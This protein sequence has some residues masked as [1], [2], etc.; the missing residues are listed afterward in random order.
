MVKANK[1]LLKYSNVFSSNEADIGKTGLVQ[2]KIE[3]PIF[4]RPRRLPVALEKEVET[5]IEGMVKDGVI[6]PSSSPWCSPVVLV[7]KKDGSMRFCVDY[8]RL[9]DATKK[10]SYPLPRIDDTLDMLT[11]V[12][13][14]STLELK[15]G[16]WQ[17]EIHPK[18][19]EKIAFST[20]K[21]L[22]Q[23]KVMPF[24]LCNAPATFERLMELVLTG[25]IGDACLVYLDDIIIIGRTFE[26]HHQNLVRVLM[27]IQ[28]A[29]LKLSPKKCS[30]F[31]RQVSF[32]GY[33]VSEEGI[34]TDPEKIA[35][36]NEWPVP[37]D[38]TQELKNR[39]C[40]T[41]I[42]GYPD[43]GKEFIVDTDASDIGLG[44]VLSQRNGD[45]EIVIAYV[46]KSLSKSERN[47]CVTRREL[48]AVVKSLQHFSKYLLGRKFHLRTDHAALK[49]LLQFKN[50][51]G[52]VARWIEL[53]QEYDFVIE[54][55]SGR[56][57]GN[58]DALSRRPCPDCTASIVLGKRVR[59]W[60]L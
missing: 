42:L 7:K 3:L 11:G 58:A 52:Q 24:V 13:W 57:H 51:E 15:S 35:A 39:L 48:L 12:K 9:N 59:K 28:S 14:F 17:V 37:K 60:Y 31:K 26:E 6:E 49:W 36:I 29:N 21:C 18:D 23:F 10:D 40:K 4:Q 33:V 55:R 47:Y 20:G 22:W 54:H 5:M 45:Q 50:P 46:C 56:S 32:L 41:P 30:L 27:K 44:G 19:K 53:L 1:L 43:A 2:H 25:L 8:R 34:R 16:Y 38:K